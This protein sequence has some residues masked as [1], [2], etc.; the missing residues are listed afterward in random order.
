MQRRKLSRL[1]KQRLAQGKMKPRATAKPAQASKPARRMS[2]AA[3]QRIVAA[4]RVR[5]AKVRAQVVPDM[6]EVAVAPWELALPSP[7]PRALA[8]HPLPDGA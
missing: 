7:L 5:W 1:L 6:H 8:K 3:R 2:K 4:Q